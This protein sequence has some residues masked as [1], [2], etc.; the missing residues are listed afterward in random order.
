MV[1]PVLE[2]ARRLGR[3]LPL[4]RVRQRANVHVASDLV[5]DRVMSYCC[6][7]SDEALLVAGVSSPCAAFLRFFGGMG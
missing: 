3:D 6:F 1:A 4:A 2:Q 7:S 5:D